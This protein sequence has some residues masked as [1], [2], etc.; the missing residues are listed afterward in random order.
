MNAPS[1]RSDQEQVRHAARQTLEERGIHP[2]PYGW[3]VNTTIAQARDD[4]ERQPPSEDHPLNVSVAGRMMTRRIMGKASFFDLQDASGR[5]QVYV[6]RDDLPPGFYNEIFK[7][8]LHIGDI[9]GIQGHVFRT[10][11]GE[12]TIHA[13]RL[14]LLSKSLRPL[15]VVK[16]QDGTTYDE[17]AD[18]ELR[19]RQRYADLAVN[20][21]VRTIF[22]QRSRM[23]T[24]LRRFLDDRGYLEVETPV[25]QPVYGG[26]TAR[27]FV[28]H[29]NALDMPLFLRIADELYLKRLIVG[30]FDGV[31]E[32]SKDFRNEG[33]SRFHN[34]EFTMLELY[35]AYK[36]Y[37][38]MMNLVEE[39]MEY[40]V[41]A[42][43]NT[44]TITVQGQEISFKRPLPRIPMYESIA[45]HT[46][47]DLYGADRDTAAQVATSLG[48]EIDPAMGHGKIIDELFGTFV[49]P[50]LVQ[51]T[52][53]TDYPVELSPLSKQHRSK[54]GL[55]E[56]FEMICNGKEL[57]NAF[58]ELNDPQEQRNRFE[59][60]ARLRAQGDEEAMQIDEDYLRALEYGMPPTAGLGVGVDRLAMLMTDQA[61]IRDVILFPLMRPKD[62]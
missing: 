49:E 17:F 42:L 55:V 35:V 34:P 16:E 15:P 33:L 4:F 56:R 61:S 29:H 53:I 30:G 48:L 14:E 26:A 52:F 31:Y 19:Y 27:P 45:E 12:V 9:I 38:W 25:L 37:V 5:M 62:S 50:H 59:E 41:T 43:H 23:V 13:T 22:E 39:M 32:I 28:T 10:Q 8:L 46:G 54:P 24:A 1:T 21:K 47:H 44:T 51:P 3:F 57:C 11:R 20:P 60:Q 7:R 58:S 2:Y 40:V 6:Q 18:K 36:D